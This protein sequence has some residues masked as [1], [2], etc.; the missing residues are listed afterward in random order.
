M[1]LSLRVHCLGLDLSSLPLLD[2]MPLPST[3]CI[4]DLLLKLLKKGPPGR[5]KLPDCFQAAVAITKGP[6]GRQ[7][8]CGPRQVESW[9]T[10][11]VPMENPC[12]SCTLTRPAL[13]R[14]DADGDERTPL[15]GPSAAAAA[16][17]SD[18]GSAAAA[19]EHST[20]GHQ[21]YSH[22]RTAAVGA[23]I[24][25]QRHSRTANALRQYMDCHPM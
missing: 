6:P 23:V 15:A 14:S 19:G 1:D 13:G 10:A 3:A 25:A 4:H 5:R 12:C 16:D 22:A 21:V 20:A 8:E 17:S 7:P 11:A 2:L 18:G 9:L 24:W